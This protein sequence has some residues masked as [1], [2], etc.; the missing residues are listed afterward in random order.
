LKAEVKARLEVPHHVV[1]AHRE[2]GSDAEVLSVFREDRGE[3]A[4]NNM[5]KLPFEFSAP[6]ARVRLKPRRGT[7]IVEC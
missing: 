7:G 6:K 1:Y 2:R 4:V 5:A 3:V